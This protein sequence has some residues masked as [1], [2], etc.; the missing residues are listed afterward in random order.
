MGN[1]GS[2]S[3]GVR[4][5]TEWGMAGTVG[6]VKEAYLWVGDGDKP[7]TLPKEKPSLP[8]ELNYDLWLGPASERP[9]HPSYLPFT[10]RGWRHFGSGQLGDMGCHT[11]NFLFRCLQLQKLWEVASKE[12][13]ES[14]LIRISGGA[15]GVNVEGYP[16]A[17]RVQ[18]EMPARGDLPPVKLTVSSGE[19]M[20]PSKDLL[21]GHGVGSFGALL[22]GSR[23]S[24]YSS[25]PWNTS[26]TILN[27]KNGLK[28]PP[29]TLPRGVDH[30][31]EWI[32]AC[33][34]K[35]KTFSPF[36]IGGPL[37]ELIQLANIGGIVGEPF[38][39]LSLIHI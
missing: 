22:V 30:H 10:W 27:R 39:Y 15:T 17:S 8:R 4:R 1:Q 11:G 24:I 18:F 7:K 36:D 38:H 29:R 19:S 23:G 5:A 13:K 33:K 37:T 20:R 21:H 14:R 3:E 31:R 28:E 6:P 34:G 35:G 9:Y 32:D 16:G 26:S 12:A 2:A 25:N